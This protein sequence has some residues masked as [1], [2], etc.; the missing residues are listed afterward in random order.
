MEFCFTGISFSTENKNRWLHLLQFQFLGF[1][2]SRQF[3]WWIVYLPPVQRLQKMV[4][5]LICFVR[6]LKKG[7][8]S[9]WKWKSWKMS[10]RNIR[11][12][13]SVSWALT[14]HPPLFFSFQVFDQTSP[15]RSWVYPG[16]FW[17]ELLISIKILTF[18]HKAHAVIKVLT[19]IEG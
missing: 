3:L 10:R 15:P 13:P 11:S 4:F 16:E 19:C 17:F 18:K 8:H 2:A 14:T 12:M 1:C 9:S 7:V 5:Y 6:K